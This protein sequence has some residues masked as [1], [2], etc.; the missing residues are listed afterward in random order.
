M[1]IFQMRYKLWLERDGKVFG[2]GPLMLLQG[3]KEHGSLSEAARGM[4]MSYNKAYN[5]IK[6][7]EGRLGS[8]L[9]TSKSGGEQGGGS[10][11]T[12]EAEKLIAAYQVFNSECEES[13]QQ[14]FRKHFDQFGL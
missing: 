4:D 9:I 2:K 7:I 10:I 11:L 13:L 12:E 5:L 6:D 1:G 8:R 3:V 14:I